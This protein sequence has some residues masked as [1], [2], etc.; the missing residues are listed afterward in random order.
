MSKCK[1]CGFS[2]PSGY[3][4][5]L[6][7]GSKI[8][9]MDVHSS[10][11]TPHG[12]N[13]PQHEQ[14]SSQ[15]SHGNPLPQNLNQNSPKSHTAYVLLAIFLGALGIHNFYAKR[16]SQGTTQL[17]ITILTCFYGGII[18]Y[19]WAIVDIINV[20]VDGNGNPFTKG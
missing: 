10:P 2:N 7:C 16:T 14:S 3:T 1:N 12:H 5:C 13:T 20:K 6:K 18:S 15:A 17:L 4:N 11:Q 19:V 8:V 9:M